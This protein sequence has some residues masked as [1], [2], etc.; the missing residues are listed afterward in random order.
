[1]KK[2]ILIFLFLLLAC[3]AFAQT[4]C[5]ERMSAISEHFGVSFIYDSSLRLDDVY[6]GSPELL[7]SL[8][9]N[10]QVLFDGT[11]ISWSRRNNYVILKALRRYELKGH[12]TD[13]ASSETLIAAAVLTGNSG[14]ITNEFGFYSITLPEGTYDISYSYLGYDS[15][16]IHLELNSDKVLNVALMS[17]A[18]LNAATIT[19]R[20]ETGIYATRAGSMEIPQIMIKNAPSLL[21]ES[22]V[23]KTM[24]MLPG[25]QAGYEGFSGVF[26]RGGGDDENLLMLDG[27][28][29]YNASHML[30]IFSVFTAEAVKK[31]SV[32]KGD[33]PARYGGRLS[34]VVDVRTNDGDMHSTHGSVS[35]GLLTDKVHL[36]GPIRKGT[37]SYSVSARMLHSFLLTPALKLF[38][39]PVNYYFYD[40]NGKLNHRFSDRD[41]IYAG[42][43][44]G[45]D[46]FQNDDIQD[47]WNGY[48]T[49]EYQRVNWGNTMGTLRWNHVYGRQLFSNLT[50]YSNNYRSKMME[51]DEFISRKRDN[52]ITTNIDEEHFRSAINDLGAKMDFD[53]NPSPKHAVKFGASAVLHRY[54]PSSYT[55]S[56]KIEDSENP[57]S[58]TLTNSREN[59]SLYAREFMMYL[60]DDFVAFERLR[61]NA[62][63]HLT[64]F[65]TQGRNYLSPQPR[66][67]AKYDI[68]RD[69]ALKAGY[70]RMAQHIHR[71]S[72]GRVGLPTD[73]WVPV[74]KNI[75]PAIADQW[76]AGLVWSGTQAWEFSADAYWKEMDSVI[77]YREAAIASAGGENWDKNVAM[78]EGRARGIEFLARKTEGA[79]TG[80]LAYTLSKSERIFRDGSVNGGRWYPYQYDRTHVLTLCANHKFNS[81]IDLSAS[82]SFASGAAMTIPTRATV[83]SSYEG[84]EYR[85]SY[86]P[87]KGNYRMPPSHRLDLSVNFSKQKIHGERIWNFGIYNVY[88]RR[89]PSVI[90]YD[91]YGDYNTYARVKKI[92]FLLFFPSVSYTYRF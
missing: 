84:Y 86:V 78:G 12:V 40:L 60:E 51:R 8:E 61:I 1:M 64:L 10:L 83:V 65:S 4:T 79:T 25:V 71:L 75:R 7:P 9:D 20:A 5:K 92:S 23:L 37:T 74:T 77:E 57:S 42:I 3:S 63:L 35:V 43:Y 87:E 72:S 67:S 76:N 82:W 17:N 54:R 11:A 53:W 73:R 39:V 66:L 13:A 58:D 6:G 44:H 38:K 27:V 85:T 36:E 55:T 81:H 22:D 90:D 26:V 69:L 15:R 70:S 19:S 16:T 29:L 49:N 34:S 91:V 47:W 18:E 52:E 62:G 50:L 68:T 2:K 45:N 56:I 89:N 88:G 46:Y 30:G 24:Q 28:P 21:G 31:V 32:Y 14:T 80:W 48:K 59:S 33:F 41:R